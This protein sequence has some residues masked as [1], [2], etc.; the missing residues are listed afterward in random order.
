MVEDKLNR[1][2]KKLEELGLSLPTPPKSSGNYLSACRVG[3]LLYI[4]GI[5]CKWNGEVKFCG[6]VGSSLSLNE[7]YE[8]A[9]ITTLNHLSIIKNMLGSFEAIEQVVKATGYINC[10]PGFPD[11]PHVMNG[12]SDLLVKLFEERGRHARC[13]VGVSSLPGNAAVETDLILSIK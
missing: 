13:A 5:T 10:A 12:A 11:I 7:G 1:I 2:E 9:Q 8:A 6:Q 3:N 4:S